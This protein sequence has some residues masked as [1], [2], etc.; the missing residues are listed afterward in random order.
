MSGFDF[1]F[2]HARQLLDELL[3]RASH[4]AT[5][6]KH[7]FSQSHQSMNHA[8][9]RNSLSPKRIHVPKNLVIQLLINHQPSP[10]RVPRTLRIPALSEPNSAD[11]PLEFRHEF[12]ECPWCVARCV[13]GWFRGVCG[14]FGVVWDI[15][16]ICEIGER[17]ERDSK[18]LLE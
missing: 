15:V 4:T 3:R 7:Q 11:D 12:I 2:R 16:I 1:V 8:S 14:W 5:G 18:L 6:P 9:P 17:C 13:R 10:I